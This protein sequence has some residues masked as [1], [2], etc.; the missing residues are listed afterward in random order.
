MIAAPTTRLPTRL[1]QSPVDA[2]PL[3]AWRSHLQKGHHA[4]GSQEDSIEVMK[5]HNLTLECVIQGSPIPHVTWTKYGGIL[6]KDRSVQ[7]LGLFL[8]ILLSLL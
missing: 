8:C 6:P 7:L 4:Q 1:V 3:Q 5:G 2:R